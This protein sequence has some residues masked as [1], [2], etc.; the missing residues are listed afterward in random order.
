MKLRHAV[1]SESI[2]RLLSAFVVVRD[3]G[4]MGHEKVMI[5]LERNDYEPE[6]CFFGRA[7]SSAFSLDQMH[8][9]APD[10]V[11]EILSPSTEM[12]D[13]GIKFEDYAAHGVDEYWLVDPDREFV[14]Q[15][16][17][18]GDTYELLIK[19]N[20]GVIESHVLPEFCVPIRAC[21]EPQGN[22]EALRR[23]LER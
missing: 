13:R 23:I 11:V 6:V 9:P 14:E 2:F 17:L 15:Y 22:M 7:K 8:F 19:S 5:S 3:L 1:V 20:S 4:Y 21:F 10:L 12:N 16:V 18:R